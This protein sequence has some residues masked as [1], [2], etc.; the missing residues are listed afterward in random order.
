MKNICQEYF[1]K[2]FIVIL[3]TENRPIYK[4]SA[5]R[6]LLNIR[7]FP[8]PFKTAGTESGKDIK[9]LSNPIPAVPEAE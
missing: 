5:D 6:K 8:R 1:V 7:F 4:I 3:C 9:S 2:N